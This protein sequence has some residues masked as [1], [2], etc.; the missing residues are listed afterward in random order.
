MALS[1]FF[2][3]GFWLIFLLFFSLFA[4]C[5]WF[6]YYFSLYAFNSK[7]K[8]PLFKGKTALIVPVYNENG[9]KLKDTII[10]AKRAKGLNQLIFVNDGSTDNHVLKILR[11]NNLDH[12][13]TIVNLQQN[14]GKRKAQ[15]SG[16]EKSDKDV[17]IFVFMDSD[18]ILRE[19]SVIELTRPMV[20]ENIGGTTACILCRNRNDNILTKAISAM[21]WSAS[22]IWRKAPSNLGFVQVTNGQLSCYRANIIR[23]LIPR[24]TNQKFM[25]GIC[26]FSDD[27]WITHHIQLDYNKKILYV[28]K[29][30]AETYIPNTFNGAYKMFLR[31]KQGSFREAFLII[32]Q[33]FKKPLLVVDV[34]ANHL[35]NIMQTIV[36]LGIIILA[37]YYPS[38]LLHY[39]V[40]IVI[41]SLLF[42]FQMIIENPKEVP[43]KIL[44]SF[45][46]EIIF[47]WITI[48]ALLKIKNQGKWGTR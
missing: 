15:K 38:I 43:Y 7:Q 22:N 3:S 25:G 23:E 37:F 42:A 39:F 20:D 24:Y 9:D 34:W 31:W 2:T 11:E 40:V 45:L 4:K 33:F 8:Y 13:Y 29:S 48:H 19:D 36:R 44:Y 32:P 41:I 27:R 14:V 35:V 1:N 6:F 10:H 26:T 5:L 30:V 28:P 18:T 46:N 17:D 47:G 21:Y 16:I 12:S